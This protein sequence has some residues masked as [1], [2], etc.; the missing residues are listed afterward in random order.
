[1]DKIIKGFLVLIPFIIILMIVIYMF[2]LLLA[3]VQYILDISNNNIYLTLSI[4]TIIIALLFT[5]GF[6]YEKQKKTFVTIVIESIV[7]KLPFL[8][9]IYFILTDLVDLLF[10]N[11]SYLGVVEIEYGGY[12]QY[13]FI[14]KDLPEENRYIVFIP[15][16]PNP[17]NGFVIL[18]DK[19]NPKYPYKKVDINSKEAMSRIISLGLK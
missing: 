6:F 5:L 4:I 16:A 17:S 7:K 14:T 19:N 9:D 10:K 2:N 12:L 11:N 13:G 15:T 1:M 3:S 18:L 8:K